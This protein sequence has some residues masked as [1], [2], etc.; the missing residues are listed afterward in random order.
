MSF[1]AYP[2][3][4][5]ACEWVGKVPRHWDVLPNKLAFRRIKTEVGTKWDSTD[6]LSLT[7]KGV[8]LRDID[9]GEGKY[10]SDFSNYQIVDRDDLVFC[11]FDMDE[12]PRTVGLS[13]H[14]GM[15]T[16]AYD[17]FRCTD[18]AIPGYVYYFYRYIDSCKKLRPFYSG[19]RKTVRTPTFLSIKIP[20]PPL[21]EQRAIASFLDEETSKIDALVSEQRRLIE[22]LKEKRQAVISHAV[23]KGLN[24]NAPMKP[25]GIPWLG[26][27]PE[28][29]SVTKAKRLAAVFVP[30][31]NKPEL[32]DR[33]DGVRWVTMEQM[34]NSEIVDSPL[35]V[36]EDAS[37]NAGSKV[38]KSGAV[39][40]SCVGQFEV[41]AINRVD[42]IINQQLQAYI[43]G[44]KINPEYLRLLIL[45]SS[46]PQSSDRPLIDR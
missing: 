29:W 27:V 44:P 28:H 6:L 38:L 12:T 46:S 36:S 30:Q 5:E 14:H 10:P 45:L 42:V 3:Y 32:N 34:Q 26:D 43:P 4:A 16:S 11:L 9:S 15:I 1:S 17:V 24:P 35:Y 33:G 19:L 25:S 13:S 18:R 37:A 31:R 2:E 7:L 20:L 40:A 39:I 23:T 21:E 22:L 8:V 41:A